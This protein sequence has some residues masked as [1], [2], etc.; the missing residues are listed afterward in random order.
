MVNMLDWAAKLLQDQEYERCIDLAHLNQKD[1]GI[2]YYAGLAFEQMRD[3]ER[4]A[5]TFLR[6]LEIDP[7]HENSLRHLTYN[8]NSDLDVLVVL[9]KMARNNIA[10]AEDMCLMAEIYNRFDRLNEA[11]HWFNRSFELEKS[12]IAA[13]GLAEIHAKMAINFIREANKIDNI[14]LLRLSEDSLTEDVLRG[15]CVS[16]DKY[17]SLEKTPEEVFYG[18]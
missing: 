9:E 2:L 1:K 15:I 6:V 12:N 8:L 4:A 3:R 16:V 17:D 11:H 14:D 18:I 10:N 7:L 13:M 5:K